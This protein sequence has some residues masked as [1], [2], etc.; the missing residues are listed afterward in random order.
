MVGLLHSMREHTTD[1]F[2]T[3]RLDK[4]LILYAID[5]EVGAFMGSADI[6]GW[7]D[8]KKRLLISCILSSFASWN[9]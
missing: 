7:Y 9:Q 3:P 5:R 4:T 6:S 8:G 2:L 1:L